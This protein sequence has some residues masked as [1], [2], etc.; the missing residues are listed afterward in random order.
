MGLLVAKI[1][2]EYQHRINAY[3]HFLLAAS[4]LTIAISAI[5]RLDLLVLL[6]TAPLIISLALWHKPPP[7]VLLWL[8][9]IS[10]SLYM[11]HVVAKMVLIGL[12]ERVGGFADNEIP[13][14]FMPP[15][16]LVCIVIAAA[17]YF[18]VEKPGQK[19]LLDWM[20]QSKVRKSPDKT[21]ST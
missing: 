15:I 10:Y 3:S 7:K 11:S 12:V 8:G 2:F 1:T 17:L 6:A 4:V 9:R 21:A 14:Y 19:L 13:L 16:L 18:F 5:Y 20:L